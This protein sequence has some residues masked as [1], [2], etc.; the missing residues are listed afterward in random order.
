MKSHINVHWGNGLM[1]YR[2]KL[3]VNQV[4]HSQ[5][6]HERKPS[7]HSL[8]QFTWRWLLLCCVPWCW[9]IYTH[10]TLEPTLL[11][12]TKI[13]LRLKTSPT[14]FFCKSSLICRM[15]SGI[16]FPITVKPSSLLNSVWLKETPS[17][18]LRKFEMLIWVLQLLELLLWTPSWL[19]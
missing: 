9:L 13:L 7:T 8:V 12:S 18:E 2:R 1:S 6:W 5:S 10:Q 14:D 15:Q 19:S 16:Y 17:S 4:K 11:A 3:S